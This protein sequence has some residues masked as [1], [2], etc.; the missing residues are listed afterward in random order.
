MSDGRNYAPDL[1]TKKALLGRD[2]LFRQSLTKGCR[3]RA[4]RIFHLFI[5]SLGHTED[6]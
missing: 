4:I 6:L 1:L 2:I 5:E 3:R